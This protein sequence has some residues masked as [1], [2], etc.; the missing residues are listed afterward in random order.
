MGPW[1]RLS[2]RLP[3]AFDAP[4]LDAWPV[5]DEVSIERGQLVFAPPPWRQEA[6]PSQAMLANFLALAEWE[7][8][9][10]GV[11]A[12]AVKWG[13]L[14]ICRHGALAGHPT[15]SKSESGLCTPAGYPAQLRE[16]LARWHQWARYMRALVN[17]A[18]AVEVAESGRPEHWKALPDWKALPPV[19]RP[20]QARFAKGDT[21]VARHAV[22]AAATSLLAV[23]PLRLRMVPEQGRYSMKLGPAVHFSALFCAL[24][25]E[26][27]QL[28]LGR[29]GR[30]IIIC[31]E[32]GRPFPAVGRRR[33]CE[34]QACQ[35]ACRA[36][37]ARRYRK[38]KG[39]R[40][41]GR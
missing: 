10:R 19:P 15:L 29:H 6:R 31:A 35:R 27:V 7:D 38:R 37:A 8:F 11:V 9:E 36:E 41:R 23:A 5:P 16:P 39:K 40:E 17:V 21:E 22:A 33:W 32:C 4:I 25:L 12:F 13:P 28:S 20:F 14:G 18:A 3:R 30:R 34:R 2:H 26:T 24:A 1:L